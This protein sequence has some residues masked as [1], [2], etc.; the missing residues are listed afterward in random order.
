MC[1]LYDISFDMGLG[2]DIV[3]M[4]GPFFAPACVDAGTRPNTHTPDCISL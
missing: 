1:L 3:S 2:P 4:T